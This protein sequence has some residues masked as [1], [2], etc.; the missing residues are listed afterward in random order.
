MASS[1]SS[2][3]T[4]EPY[5]IVVNARAQA[6]LVELPDALSNDRFA[7]DSAPVFVPHW[8][9]ADSSVRRHP[10]SLAQRRL[11]RGEPFVAPEGQQVEILSRLETGVRSRGNNDSAVPALTDSGDGLSAF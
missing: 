5:E 6:S 7:T 1:P 9:E 3:L 2:V 11:D 4:G 8:R 10:I